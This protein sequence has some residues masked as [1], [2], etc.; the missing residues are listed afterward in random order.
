MV[1]KLLLTRLRLKP[2]DSLV[3][4]VLEPLS[5]DRCGA[6]QEDAIVG[7]LRTAGHGPRRAGTAKNND[8]NQEDKISTTALLLCVPAVR[9]TSVMLADGS[10]SAY[11][12]QEALFSTKFGELTKVRNKFLRMSSHTH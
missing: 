1:D 8:G 9:T 7:W 3:I 4:V 2:V 5:I 10:V 11:G 12:R 6:R